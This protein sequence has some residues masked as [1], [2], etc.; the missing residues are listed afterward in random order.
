GGSGVHIGIK[1]ALDRNIVTVTGTIAINEKWSNSVTVTHPADVYI[2]MLKERLLKKGVVVTG[3]AR[4][5]HPDPSAIGSIGLVS[6]NPFHLQI[7]SP[8][9]SE[10]AAKTLKPS[11]NMYTETILW[12]LGEEIGRKNGAIGDSAALG[13]GIVKGFLHQINLA[14]DAIVMYDGSGMSR[15]DLVTPDAVVRLYMYMA[16]QSP[17]AVA[18]RDALA[19]GGVDGT[20]RNRFKGTRAEGNFHGKTG[21]LDQVSAL[22]GYVTTA[23]G[24]QLIVSVIVNNVPDITDRLRIIDGIVVQLANYTGRVDP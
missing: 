5:E 19:V 23:S 13:I 24:E 9:F 4:A 14:P 16:K 12:T 20:L 8:P 2:A 11:Q 10:I 15:H 17:N 6:G 3:T 21:T 1:K 18:W 7:E 22:S